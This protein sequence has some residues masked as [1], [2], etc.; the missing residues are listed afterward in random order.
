MCRQWQEA[1]AEVAS[2]CDKFEAYLF[3]SKAIY[4]KVRHIRDRLVQQLG[5]DEGPGQ[6]STASGP[7]PTSSIG[8][9]RPQLLRLSELLLLP[10]HRGGVAVEDGLSHLLALVGGG[11]AAEAAGSQ[12]ANGCSSWLGVHRLRA[13]S[14]ALWNMSPLPVHV[15]P[16]V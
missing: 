6:P 9:S 14:T 3:R 15:P 11:V 12:G 2:A 1:G 10:F 5:Q 7:P 16:H 4:S 13:T 8:H